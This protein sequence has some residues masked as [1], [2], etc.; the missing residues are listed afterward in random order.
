VVSEV[1][2]MSEELALFA[3]DYATKLGAQ[4]SEARVHRIE[5]FE[6]ISRN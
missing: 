1:E 4:Y 5:E 3:I 2:G 6:V